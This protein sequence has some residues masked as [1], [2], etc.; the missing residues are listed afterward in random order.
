CCKLA[1]SPGCAPRSHL[2]SAHS[3][4]AMS[5][6]AKAK[7]PHSPARVFIAPVRRRLLRDPV[8]V[9][10]PTD[11]HPYPYSRG[12]VFITPDP[13]LLKGCLPFARSRVR[14]AWAILPS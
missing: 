6:P 1:C 3:L 4:E 8:S 10:R 12:S 5:T 2:R 11:Q 7:S 9:G 14:E 13:T